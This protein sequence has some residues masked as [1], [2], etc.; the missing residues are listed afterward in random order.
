MSN[1]VYTSVPSDTTT[2]GTGDGSETSKFGS[3]FGLVTKDGSGNPPSTQTANNNLRMYY[4]KD[5][6]LVQNMRNCFSVV[7]DFKDT[8]DSIVLAS[9]YGGFAWMATPMDPEER[10]A[11]VLYLGVH[12]ATN[13][14][15][16]ICGNKV[17]KFRI[18]AED[19]TGCVIAFF[20]DA[21]IVY[22]DNSESYDLSSSD[23]ESAINELS[24]RSIIKSVVIPKSEF[25]I[26]TFP[27]DPS[28][29]P[30][31]VAEVD[32]LE[33]LSTD[34]PNVTLAPSNPSNETVTLG[35]I[36]DAGHI[37]RIE[38]LNQKIKVYCHDAYIPKNNLRLVF[39][40]LRGGDPFK[41]SF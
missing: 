3:T 10:I 39:R 33:I 27:S 40:I 6:D 24:H 41:K 11:G 16:N 2:S 37:S 4:N 38:T 36:T 25:N 18:Q 9:G 8:L 31:S 17:T 1:I 26:H 19:H 12:S 7:G 5:L 29:D 23:L 30:Y 13:T 35:E 21:D 14:G 32:F 28:Q 15:T 22:Y 34:Y 20:S